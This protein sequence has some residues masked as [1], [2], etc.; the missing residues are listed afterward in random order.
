MQHITIRNFG[1][2]KDIDI[3]LDKELEVIIGHQASGKSTFSKA[4]FFCKKIRDY[5]VQ[6]LDGIMGTEYHY[7][8]EL[9]VKFLK[10]IRRPFMGYFG[11]TKHMAPFTIKYYYEKESNRYVAIS[12][13]DDHFAK[14]SFSDGMYEEICDMIKQVVLVSKQSKEAPFA[15]SF[16]EHRSTLEKM[17][18]PVNDIFKDDDVLVYVPA[19]RNLLAIIPDA[20]G[21]KIGYIQNNAD[22]E[23]EIDISQI[24]LITQE[25]IQY[26]RNMRADFG[27]R[28]EEMTQNYLKTV[29]G[30]IKNHHVEMAIELIR[31]ILRADYI[32]DKDGEKLFYDR[33]HWVKLMFGS[34]GQQEIVWALNII[35]LAILKNEKTFLVF[36]EPESHLFPDSQVVIAQLVAFMIH[37]CRSRAIITTHSPYMLTAVNLLLY[38]GKEEENRNKDTV[39][40]RE[41]RLQPGCVG[42]YF[43]SHET[44]NLKDIVGAKKGLIDALAIDGASDSINAQMDKILENSVRNR[45]IS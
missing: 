30:Q 38:S 7:N 17:K 27:S 26:I 20:F 25:F 24:D 29:K 19:G 16:L 5:F 11:T 43:L 3:D 9:Y 36:E 21:K 10:F 23:L 32:C 37:S 1:P 28:L 12:L 13:D 6:Y 22:A 44:G 42:A 14:F 33:D 40:R 4:V 2:I 35:F 18:V 41:L 45:G 8:D 31:Q 15:K 34:S 39:I